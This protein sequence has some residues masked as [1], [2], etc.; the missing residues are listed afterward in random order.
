MSKIK[1]FIDENGLKLIVKHRKSAIILEVDEKQVDNQR[2]VFNFKFS[3]DQFI[4]FYKYMKTIANESWRNIIP[5][6][7]TSISSDYTEYYDNEFDN[8]GY[9]GIRENGLQIERPSNSSNKLYQF[10]KRRIESFLYD[11]EK[12]LKLNAI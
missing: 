10:N 3:P 9:L 4:E 12:R 5:R 1:E 2:Y 7:A 11:L 8:N 6:E